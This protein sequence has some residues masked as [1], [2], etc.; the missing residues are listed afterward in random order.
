MQDKMILKRDF[1][2]LRFNLLLGFT[3]NKGSLEG[4]A[5]SDTTF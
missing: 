3:G 5:D 4:E 2:S 1:H